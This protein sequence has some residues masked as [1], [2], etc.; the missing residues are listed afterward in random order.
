MDRQAHR[1][2]R[3][4]GVEIDT[5]RAC[6]TRNSKELHV[7]Q[8]TFQVLVFLLEHRERLVTKDELIEQ[9]WGDIAVTENALDQCLAEIRRLLGDNSRQPRFLKTIPRSG[10][11]FI[12]NVTETHAP[13]TGPAE[14]RSIVPEVTTAQPGEPPVAHAAPPSRSRP[15]LIGGAVLM[16]VAVSLVGWYVLRQ[17]A[18]RQSLVSTTLAQDPAK[19]PVAVMFFDN[20]SGSADLDWLREGLADMIIADLSRSNNL[21]VLSRQQLHVLLDRLGHHPADKITLDEALNVARQ[22]QAKLLVLGSFAKLG[23]Q[24]RVDVQLHDA[25]DG[26]LLTAE[27]L[28]VD[29]P[30]Q[31]L[32]QIDLLALKLATYIGASSQ[33]E[34]NHGV[35][36][37]MT[38]NLA[39]FRNYSL[40]VEKAQRL[41]SE[42]AIRLFQQAI[43]LD[44]NFAMAYARIGFVIGVTGSNPDKAKPYLQKAFQLTDRLTEKDKLQI[45]AWYE[46]VNFDYAAAINTFRKIL[47][48]YPL[49]VEAYRR[50]AALLRGEER[51][52]EA[53]EVLKLGLVIDPGAEDLYNGLGSVYSQ[54]GRHDEAIAMF[55]RYV[56]LAP[57][58]PNS[59]DSL[60]LG[61][62][63]AGR[64]DEAIQEYQ[65]ALQLQ[66]NFEIAMAHLANVYFQQGRYTAAIEQY[67]RYI[68]VAPSNAERV[69]GYI[70]IGY[71][72]L[73]RGDVK[74]AEAAARQVTEALQRDA[75][76]M[77]LHYWLALH[78][79][80]LATAAKLK[81]N[82]EKM[83]TYDRGARSSLRP[84][85]FFRGMYALKSGA[86]DEAIEAFKHAIGQRPQTWN[87]DAYEDCLANAYLELGR[88]DEAVA[89][90]QRI[91]K[92]NPNYPLVHY[93][94]A[95]AYERKGLRDRGRMEYERFLEVWKDAGTDVPEIINARKALSG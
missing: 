33:P 46:T 17:R 90:Y 87:I 83:P 50:L 24:I 65:S 60:G 72:E 34:T 23:E 2:Y 7:R 88:L 18:A 84:L 79:N 53:I 15:V 62:Q 1:I 5:A 95:Q 94:L 74:A 42:E 4:D 63:W 68:K 47:A 57:G 25:R 30:A 86:R 3:L 19:R 91:S 48:A 54:M 69:R 58:E 64:Y 71:I 92:L 70:S 21:A 8:K 93:R 76:A 40:G 37:T 80:D 16:V 78:R 59:H 20:Q 55:Q 39:A 31:I 44:S 14:S 66:P 10:Y 85:W 51:P 82:M 32:T 12:G 6:V 75:A 11:R 22:T 61:Y 89:E 81:S 73:R 27:R 43:A 56:Q 41:R 9:L 26:Q 35:A 67:Q 77:G 38:S 13:Q 49:E 45:Q 36:Q 52:Q 29:Q 28:V